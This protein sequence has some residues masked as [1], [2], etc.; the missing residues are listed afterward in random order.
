MPAVADWSSRFRASRDSLPQWRGQPRYF[1]P[2]TR[3]HFGRKASLPRTFGRIPR[4]SF[5]Y[6]VNT[7]LQFMKTKGPSHNRRNKGNDSST[8]CVLGIPL[9]RIKKERPTFAGLPSRLISDGL[10]RS[11]AARFPSMAGPEP[12]LV[13]GATGSHRFRLPSPTGHRC[14]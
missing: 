2:C 3:A 11:G 12:A 10:A 14:K 4:K 1:A 8:A 7:S 6:L 9:R 13:V 5:V